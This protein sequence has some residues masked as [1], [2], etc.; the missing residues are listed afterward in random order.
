MHRNRNQHDDFQQGN[1][2]LPQNY[3]Y[4]CQREF[5][6]PGQAMN[7]PSGQTSINQGYEN[8]EWDYMSNSG[9]GQQS[10]GQGN[11]NPQ[12]NGNPFPGAGYG[13]VIY[14]R[15]TQDARDN[16]RRSYMPDNQYF[17]QGN[18]YRLSNSNYEQHG[19]S[20]QNNYQSPQNNYRREGFSNNMGQRG[21]YGTSY[22][23]SLRRDHGHRYQQ[24]RYDDHLGY[25]NNDFENQRYEGGFI[26]RAGDT[27]RQGWK[28]AENAIRQGWNQ[29][30]NPH[31]NDIGFHSDPYHSDYRNKRNRNNE[32]QYA[33]RN[34]NLNDNI[35]YNR[36]DRHR[37]GGTGSAWL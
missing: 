6:T 21:N 14:A 5:Y 11:Y 28:S 8:N 26:E 33:N 29:V 22:E 17:S 20:G 19:N 18:D 36:D 7:F 23:E 1:Y 15:G 34:R 3:G 16:Y 25:A 10:F 4:S 27:M 13:N 9:G 31:E 2:D 24:E 12:L 30:R 32:R 35:E 37:F